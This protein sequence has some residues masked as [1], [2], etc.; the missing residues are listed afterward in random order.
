M[1]SMKNKM[2]LYSWTF[3]SVP[4]ITVAIATTG[5]DPAAKTPIQAEANG[6]CATFG[7]GPGRNMVNTVDKNIPTEWSYEN[8][9]MKNVK[10]VARV[11]TNSYGGPVVAGNKVLVGTNNESPRNPLGVVKCFNAADGKLLWQAVHDALPPEIGKEAREHGIPST[12]SVEGNR[13]YYVNNRCEVICA[14]VE[15]EPATKEA[16]IIWRLDMIKELGV[17]PHKLPNCSPLIAGDMLFITTGNGI[18]EEEVKNPKAP[19]FIAVDKK[20]GKVK[21]QDNSPGDQIVMGQWSNPAY[22]V[23]NGKAQVIFGGG[24]GWLRAFEPET[25]KPI[26]WFNC[27]PKNDKAKGGRDAKN[28]LVATPVVNDNKVYVGVGQEPS[29]GSGVGHLWCIDITKTGDVSPVNDNLDPK[30]EINKKSALVWHY[31]GLADAKAAE[32][33]GSDNVFG[34]TVSTC[35]IHDGLV[36]AAE[37]AGFIHCLDAK[38][39]KRYWI[40]DLKAD[41]WGSPY[42]VDGKI[43]VGTGD[44]TIGIFAHGKEKKSLPN[45]EMANAVYSTP[46]AVSGVLYILTMRE[47]VAIK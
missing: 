23:V 15:G 12:P 27:N 4:V 3:L 40:H 17:F 24:D 28:Y 35:A 43:Y 32:E 21:W 41:I 30:A 25:G 5:A 38:T 13:V 11:G 14:D 34:R 9:Q 31:G 47:L 16:K 36:Y 33:T 45:V 42:Y 7:C 18:D 10:W 22:A 8:G 37:L 26:W 44:G 6:S 39:G 20:T 1:P 29:L 19:S 46:I 2:Q